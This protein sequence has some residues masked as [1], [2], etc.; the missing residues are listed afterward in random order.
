MC[1]ECASYTQLTCV[2]R[3]GLKSSLLLHCISRTW[4]SSTTIHVAGLQAEQLRNQF[5]S[6]EEDTK[7]VQKKTELLL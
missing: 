5:S 3:S 6:A 4:H 7:R 1:F 2:C